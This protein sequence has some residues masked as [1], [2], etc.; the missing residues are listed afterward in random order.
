MAKFGEFEWWEARSA[1]SL[2]LALKSLNLVTNHD[3]FHD[4]RLDFLLQERLRCMEFVIQSTFTCKK[5]V[6]HVQ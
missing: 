6:A 2:G 5:R 3:A 1:E 4:L